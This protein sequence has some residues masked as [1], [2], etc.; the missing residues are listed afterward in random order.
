MRTLFHN[1]LSA[2]SRKVRV[3][4]RE[5]NLDFELKLER[6][7]ERRVDFLAMNPAGEIP[8]LV[9]ADGLVIADVTAICEYLEEAYPDRPVLGRTP[10]ERAEVR[11]LVAWF[12]HK[13]NR[14]VTVNLVEEKM[15]KRFLGLGEPNSLAIRAG[16]ANIHYHLDYIAYLTDRRKYLAGE[17][18]SLADITA[19][20]HL[21]TLDYLGDVPWA[22]HEPAKDWYARVK[23]RPS[24][25]PLLTDLIAGAPPPPHYADLDF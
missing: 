16:M 7:W 24:F 12:D 13:F 22:Q 9:E 2:Y 20:A 14:E 23:S 6:V 21:S 17:E 11:R 4:L 3:L 15:T 5:K 18:F 10:A 25:R 19:A 8:V 1:W